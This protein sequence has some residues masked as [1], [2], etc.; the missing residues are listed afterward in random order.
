MSSKASAIK[1]RR[2]DDLLAANQKY[3][4]GCHNPEVASQLPPGPLKQMSVITCMDPR[5]NPYTA[6]GLKE[7][8]AH[9][10]R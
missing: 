2:L 5:I 7:G 4:E 1:C 6:F 3:V 10:I 9:I 8:D